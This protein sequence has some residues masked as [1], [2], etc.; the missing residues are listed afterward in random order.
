MISNLYHSSSSSRSNTA[1][2]PSTMDDVDWRL[3]HNFDALCPPDEFDRVDF[4]EDLKDILQVNWVRISASCTHRFTTADNLLK[5]SDGTA[6]CIT[7]VKEINREDETKNIWVVQAVS[8]HPPFK[9]FSV[10]A[11]T[12]LC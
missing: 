4:G 3:F 11:H 5:K 2:R 10:S 12:A 6:R 8:H 1:H 9:A 7:I